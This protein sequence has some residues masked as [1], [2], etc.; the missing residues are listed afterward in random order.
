MLYLQDSSFSDSYST[1]EALISACSSSSSGYGAYAF[2]SKSGVEILMQDK[3]FELL[4]K[5]GF[6][7]M[8]V[9]IDNITDETCLQLLKS[10]M[11]QYPNLTVKAYLHHDSNSLF[12]PKISFFKND[13][14]RGSLIVGSGNL[15]LGGL[16]KNKE[17]FGIVE[18]SETQ[19]TNTENHWLKW[20]EESNG[21]LKDIDDPEVLERARKN[22]SIIRH[23]KATDSG[24]LV[25]ETKIEEIIDD[26]SYFIVDE[27]QDEYVYDDWTYTAESQILITEISKN[28]SRLKQ[29]NF[30]QDTFTGFFGAK[31]GDNSQR[32]L[33]RSLNDEN[34]LNP[35]EVRTSVTVKSKNYRFELDDAKGQYPT[36]GRP[37]GVFIRITT[38]VF[39]YKVFMPS[40][41]FHSIIN[42]LLPERTKGRK[43]QMKQLITKISEVS[44]I[45]ENSIF[46]QYKT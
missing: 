34:H 14:G 37:I 25:D 32:I 18:L 43:D 22:K 21:F 45:I 2:A 10:I 35:I 24:S 3:E 1:H 8:I 26:K 19:Y 13:Q 15:T 28:G 31:K 38:R 11:V 17:A 46:K 5:R 16:R 36:Q 9:G 12:H 29:V 41:D 39:I 33:L 4:L 30:N 20:I 27:K 6:Y 40:D 42:K 7:S 44:D 23:K